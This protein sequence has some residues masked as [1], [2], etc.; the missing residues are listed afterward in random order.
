MRRY[1][2]LP[3]LD[4]DLLQSLMWDIDLSSATNVDE[5][6]GVAKEHYQAKRIPATYTP[7]TVA[8]VRPQP[9]GR[10]SSLVP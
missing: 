4:K 5:L 2:T 7:T 1:E 8:G 10:R 9:L 6:Y 3:S